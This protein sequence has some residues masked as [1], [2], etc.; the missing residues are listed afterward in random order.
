MKTS[1]TRS[2]GFW[3]L[4][5]L[6]LISGVVGGWLVNSQLTTMTT[7]LLDGTATGIEVYVG[8]SM[9]VLGSALIGAGILGVLIALALVAVR[10][11]LPASAP[12]ALEPIDWSTRPEADD[13][14]DGE[15][16]D[17]AASSD[18]PASD[19][20]EESELSD[21]PAGR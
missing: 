13:A 21:A 1:L 15:M 7:T 19:V 12:A 4:L 14:P 18:A 8:Q 9:V 6:S 5:A 11:V 10:S 17:A 16:S 2:I 3:L 20:S